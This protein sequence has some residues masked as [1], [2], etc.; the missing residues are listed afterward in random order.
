MTNQGRLA[1]IGEV[2]SRLKEFCNKPINKSDDGYAPVTTDDLIEFLHIIDLMTEIRFQRD[3]D[4]DLPV[5]VDILDK[6]KF[7]NLIDVKLPLSSSLSR[8]H[9]LIRIA[10]RANELAQSDIGNELLEIKKGN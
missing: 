10:N 5:S 7:F 4:G 2:N 9:K 6:T 1:K 3:P 8:A